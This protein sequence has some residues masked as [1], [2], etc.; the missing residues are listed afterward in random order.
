MLDAYTTCDSW[1]VLRE[2]NPGTRSGPRRILIIALLV[3]SLTEWHFVA[4]RKRKG[5]FSPGHNGKV[6]LDEN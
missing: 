4:L 6:L 5:H 3:T 1:D 2:G